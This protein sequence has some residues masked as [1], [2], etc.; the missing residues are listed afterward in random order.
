MDIVIDEDGAVRDAGAAWDKA[1]AFLCDVSPV[2]ICGT[3]GL[4]ATHV[5]MAR[6]TIE[7]SEHK[8]GSAKD[9]NKAV[10]GDLNVFKLGT[11]LSLGG[12]GDVGTRQASRQAQ[13]STGKE[14]TVL[15]DVSPA[16]QMLMR[17]WA[18]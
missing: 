16:C 13:H 1:Q 5:S 6:G 8:S 12:S 18:V 17:S 2:A 15:H 14:R 9:N 11:H 10:S 4:G 7:N 3:I